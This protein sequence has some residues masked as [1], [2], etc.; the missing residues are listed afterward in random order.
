[1]LPHLRVVGE[2]KGVLCVQLKLI[3]FQLRQLVNQTFQGPKGWHFTTTDVEHD[4]AMI[5]VGLIN[6]FQ[7]RDRAAALRRLF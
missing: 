3:E 2:R 7:T 5:E 1:M 6:D 4:A